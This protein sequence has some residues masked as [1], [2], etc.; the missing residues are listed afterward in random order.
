MLSLCLKKISASFMKRGQIMSQL[1]TESLE[2]VKI[3]QTFFE[4]KRLEFL[5][6]NLEPIIYKLTHNEDGESWNLEDAIKYAQEYRCWLFICWMNPDLSLPPSKKI[7]H[8]WHM[9]A[10]DSELYRVQTLRL[11]RR[12]FDH[13]PYFGVRSELDKQNLQ[14]AFENTKK[15]MSLYADSFGCNF[16]ALC[17][18]S[19]GG[20]LCDNNACDS[21]SCGKLEV[22]SEK[23]EEYLLSIRPDRNG[24][25]TGFM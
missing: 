8:V 2:L 11:F 5:N 13:F 12:Y 10:L 25:T 9:H 23:T 6:L 19:C 20:S 4:S 22:F 21:N 14:S 15:L 3:N 7:D 17:G 18:N 16:T 1:F 24:I